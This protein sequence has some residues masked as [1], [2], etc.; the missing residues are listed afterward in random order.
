[1]GVRARPSRRSSPRGK[2]GF[3]AVPIGTTP[4][5]YTDATAA[6][7]QVRGV[8]K[9]LIKR[10]QT[11]EDAELFM[12]YPRRAP[13]SIGGVPVTLLKSELIQ[14]CLIGETL[15]ERLFQLNI[16]SLA[17]V[18]ENAS[19]I[20]K[21]LGLD[22]DLQ[23]ATMQ[24][25]IGRNRNLS[26]NAVVVPD[27]K[28]PFIAL[29]ADFLRTHNVSVFFG[30]SHYGQTRGFFRLSGIEFADSCDGMVIGPMGEK[31]PKFF[32]SVIEVYTDG[33]CSFNGQPGAR[34][35]YAGIFPS[36]PKYDFTS[37]LEGEVQ[38]SNRAEYA[39]VKTA[40]RQAQLIDP[41][42]TKTL[43]IYT[44]SQLLIDSMT[45]YLPT[46]KANGWRKSD[47]QPVLNRDL[48]ESIDALMKRRDKVEFIH[49]AA[50]DGGATKESRLNEETDRRARQA[51]SL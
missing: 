33:A 34:A 41:S 39:A 11:L 28:D 45:S 16:V 51:I 2:S 35:G 4:G 18:T 21:F 22:G 42:R 15:F 47:G 25:T 36:F 31:N 50:H 32:D 6:F 7:A 46:W 3:F 8:K 12:K 19:E 44:D 24:L 38:T 30:S 48:L 43:K 9:S 40:L 13:A 37:P 10:F 14:P 27:L 29:G 23:G 17:P 26:L 5:I 49:V 20:S 1:M